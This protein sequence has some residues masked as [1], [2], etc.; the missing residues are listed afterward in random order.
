M[1]NNKE[2]RL[3]WSLLR[4][5][6][7]LVLIL[8]GISIRIISFFLYYYRSINSS[9]GLYSLGDVHL[10]F[11]DLNSIFTGEWIWNQS[12]LAYP[13][14][15]IYFLFT[16]RILA[17][18]NIYLFYFYSFILEI[19][20]V[21]L[22][23]VVLKKFSIS[24]YKLI[25]GLVLVNPFYLACYVFRVYLSGLRITDSLF[26]LFLL[27]SLYFYAKDKKQY[28]YLFSGLAMCAKWYTLP[29]LVLFIVK[30]LLEKDWKEIEL[31]LVYIGIPIIVF[32]VSPVFYLPNYLD[33]YFSWLSGHGTTSFIPIYYK[34]IPISLVTLI[35][36]IKIKSLSDIDIIFL[37]F[38]IMVSLMW[39]SRFY[40][41]YLAPL[42]YFGHLNK[43]GKVYFYNFELKG[44]KI[45]L[46]M[47]NHVLTFIASIFAA[48]FVI[49][50]AY[51]E[52]A[53]YG[54]L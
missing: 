15:S 37:S 16:L 1:N 23:Y 9:F 3:G 34:L 10:N 46:K 49:I 13:P 27:L 48:I 41:R 36:L 42:I 43:Q 29:A 14:L 44:S 20:V 8:L 25:F 28:F 12:E 47:N 51:V 50:I 17:F 53:A 18:N 21:G 30:Y 31:I 5:N 52:L 26:C 7:Y 35:I 39:W 38:I 4:K 45:N 11:F 24:N 22:F 19:I 54:L 32:L 2:K 33:L 40:L 6:I